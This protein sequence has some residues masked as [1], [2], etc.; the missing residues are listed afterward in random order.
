MYIGV[1]QVNKE[2]RIKL[3]NEKKSTLRLFISLALSIGYETSMHGSSINNCENRTEECPKRRSVEG[4][5][6]VA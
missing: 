4:I 1:L 6:W 3:D 2:R 5:G